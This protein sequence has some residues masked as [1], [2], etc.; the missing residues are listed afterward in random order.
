M[1]LVA[2]PMWKWELSI[3]RGSYTIRR[4]H[5]KGNGQVGNKIGN[6][7]YVVQIGSASP[8]NG[9]ISN[10]LYDAPAENDVQ[11]K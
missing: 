6:L 11:G 5:G 2:M 3:S 7:V 9:T 4:S 1:K 8:E 10:P